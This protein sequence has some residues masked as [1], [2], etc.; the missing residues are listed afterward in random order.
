MSYELLIPD[1][2]KKGTAKDFVIEILTKD[3]P[4]TLKELYY[5]IK[6]E[7][8]F[9][10]SY[11]S[12]FK[13]VNELLEKKVLIRRGK[14]YEI[15]ISWIKNLQSFTDIVETNYYAEKKTKEFLNKR[16]ED[17]V[18]L[19]FNSIFDLEKYL[20]YFVKN[21]LKKVKNKDV[22]YSMEN[23][24]K[25]LFYYRAEYNYYLKLM[26]RGHKFYFLVNGKS[27]IEN[28]A[29]EF[30]KKLGIKVRVNREEMSTDLIVF[31][32]YYIEI[33]VPH[34]FKMRI[35]K[36]LIEGKRFELLKILD[37]ELNCKI[38]MHKDKG[39]SLGIQEKLKK[40]F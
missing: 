16:K 27:E 31:N 7:F 8:K 24:W 39:L 10:G 19:N 15:N 11:Q 38:I 37:E 32:D 26:K 18:I 28:Y 4:L 9:S 33:F 36:L 40:K 14:T 1:L 20:Y 30:Y 34:E 22:F 17:V 6:K 25:V 13:S 29:K 23:L 12:V 21:E 3:W 35:N 2:G 5:R